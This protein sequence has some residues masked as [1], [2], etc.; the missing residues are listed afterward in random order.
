MTQLTC[1]ICKATVEHEKYADHI[2]SH[3]TAASSTGATS[4]TGRG[5]TPMTGRIPTADYAGGNYLTGSDVPD[6]VSEVSFTLI[7]FVNDPG[8]R[9]KMAA[10]ISETF[11]KRMFG[12]NTTNIRVLASLGFADLQDVCGHIIKCVVGYQPN[13][14]RQN[15]PTKALF[16]S[17]VERPAPKA[18]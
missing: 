9:S 10:Q 2:A 6:G 17:G 16:I 4:Q 13:P 7:N 8:G 5:I 15:M 18:S 3:S 14:Q 11:G 12:L 1:T